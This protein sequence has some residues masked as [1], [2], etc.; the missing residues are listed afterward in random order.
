MPPRRP[1]CR[2]CE[3]RLPSLRR[4]S[5]RRDLQ[6]CY[7]IRPAM[8]H[9]RPPPPEQAKTALMHTPASTN[10]THA[11]LPA[12]ELSSGPDGAPRLRLHADVYSRLRA[13]TSPTRLPLDRCRDSVK[14]RLDFGACVSSS[15]PYAAECVRSLSWTRSGRRMD[16]KRWCLLTVVCAVCQPSP[17]SFS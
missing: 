9:T 13:G 4:H 1:D 16:M 3:T 6:H 2:R 5:L 7:G 8:A 15:S 10:T 14:R 11:V 12:P 17:V